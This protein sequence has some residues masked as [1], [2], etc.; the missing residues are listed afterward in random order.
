MLAQPTEV[1]EYSRSSFTNGP[2][3][4]LVSLWAVLL[5]FQESVSDVTGLTAP[6]SMFSLGCCSIKLGPMKVLYDLSIS[7]L[8]QEDIVI[9]GFLSLDLSFTHY[10]SKGQRLL[11]Q[12]PFWLSEMVA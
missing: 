11:E 7:K 2:V 8:G 1:L 12:S 5:Q 6:I 4:K 10:P 9:G 3:V